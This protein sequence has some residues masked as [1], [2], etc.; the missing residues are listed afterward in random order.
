MTLRHISAAATAP[1]PDTR[2]ARRAAQRLGK[3][4]RWLQRQ[5]QQVAK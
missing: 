3:I 1:V 5:Q 2:R 4:A